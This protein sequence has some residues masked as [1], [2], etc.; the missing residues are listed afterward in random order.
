MFSCHGR[1]NWVAL[2]GLALSSCGWLD[3]EHDP[4]PNSSDWVTIVDPELNAQALG[5]LKNHCTQCHGSQSQAAGRF[6][7]IHDLLSMVKQGLII[8]GEA[9]RSRLYRRIL[10]R[11]MAP[12]NPLS[13][14]QTKLIAHWINHGLAKGKNHEYQNE[15]PFQ[16]D[17]SAK[18][19]EA[20]TA[21]LRRLSKTEY[22]NTIS[23][24]IDLVTTPKI[25]KQIKFNIDPSFEHIPNDEHLV[26]SR[27]DHRISSDHIAGFFKVAFEVGDRVSKN[28][29]PCEDQMCF[30][31]FVERFGLL[32]YRRP[33]SQNE[34]EQLASYFD[35]SDSVEGMSN[36]IAHLLMAPEFIYHLEVHGQVS[37][38]A[39]KLDGYSLASRLSYT[40]WHTMP[41]QTLLSAAAMGMLDTRQGVEEVVD[42]VF[43]KIERGAQPVARF[44]FEWL[45]LKELP[46]V[47]VSVATQKL[48]ADLL[49]GDDDARTLFDR[50]KSQSIED[51][52]SH[53]VSSIWRQQ[54]SFQEFFES[55]SSQITDPPF[56]VVYGGQRAGLLTRPALLLARSFRSNPVLRGAFIRKHILCDTLSD[57]DPND[58]P[59]DAMAPPPANERQSTR[60]FVTRQTGSAR[61]MGCHN[62]INPLGFALERYDSLGQKRSVERLW[63][64][65][66]HSLPDV[67]INTI[68]Q[69]FVVLGDITQTQGASQLVDVI[70][71]SGKARACFAKNYFQFTLARLENKS[72]ACFLKSFHQ[73]L[74]SGSIKESLLKL[75]RSKAFRYRSLNSVG[76]TP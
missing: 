17:P 53:S 22:V 69:P 52:L 35:P 26:F 76:S 71:D 25:S 1:L 21:P 11:T 27:L 63:D 20:L 34:I 56:S 13:N 38:N 61:C 23:D 75:A 6:S 42:Y 45:G 33:L 54:I 57:P 32:A 40:F 2:V 51:V 44:A 10:D 72:D 73:D 37:R 67:A 59:D 15:G 16:C 55:N 70:L 62:R 14:S 9:E 31:N 47:E 74:K 12:A 58:L 60:N 4:P 66:G 36:A 39:L 30:K 24:I 48:A 3:A 50:L 28:L 46:D 5:V 64:E 7:H 8:P 65:Q 49:T 19:V 18:P 29:P 41:D 43:S 68:T